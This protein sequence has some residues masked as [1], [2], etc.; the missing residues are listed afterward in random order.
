MSRWPM[1]FLSLVM[2]TMGGI[3]LGAVLGVVS[4]EGGSFLAPQPVIIALG[5]GLVIGGLLFVLPPQLPG[6]LR[7]LAFLTAL[8]F[9]AFV[10]NWTAFAPQVIYESSTSFGPITVIGRD[11]IG[12]RIVFGA[13]ALALDGIILWG[14]YD[15]LRGLMKDGE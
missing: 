2:L 4:T 13:V 3:I 15:W 6:W 12:G 9:M 7:S 8:C 10:C 1:L 11:Q 5:L 14:M